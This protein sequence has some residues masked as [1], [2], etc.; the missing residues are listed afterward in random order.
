MRTRMCPHTRTHE[1]TRTLPQGS[2]V[3]QAVMRLLPDW[4]HVGTA[5]GVLFQQDA[6]ELPFPGAIERW[7]SVPHGTAIECFASPLNHRITRP[8][9]AN[10]ARGRGAHAS[11]PPR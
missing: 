9:D 2:R 3:Q 7:A 8:A 11:V 6:A 10:G 4:R 5:N 1:R